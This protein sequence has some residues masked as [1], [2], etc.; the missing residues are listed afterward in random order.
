MPAALI[1]R[2]IGMSR[3]IAENGEFIPVTLVQCAPATVIQLRTPAKD[4]TTAVVLATEERDATAKHPA[5]RFRLISQFTGDF[6]A[7]LGAQFTVDSFA[8]GDSVQLVATTK[9]RGFQ[10]VVKRHG[11]SGFPSSHGHDGLRIPGSLGTR[12]PRRVKPGRR[13]PGHMG[14]DQRTVRNVPVMAVDAARG[15]I[16]VKGS[17][18]GPNSGVVYISKA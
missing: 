13:L 10:G 5:R 11:F 6:G 1:G 17:I 9:G 7:E 8:A 3:I 18:A 15:L 4:N 16:A 14:V 12:K 2:K